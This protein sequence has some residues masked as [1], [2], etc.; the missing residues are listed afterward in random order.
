MWLQAFCH[1]LVLAGRHKFPCA[2]PRICWFLSQTSS[3]GRV[4]SRCITS[5]KQHA[6][7][8]TSKLAPGICTS[9]E[10][11]WCRWLGS[12]SGR[13]RLSPNALCFTWRARGILMIIALYCSIPLQ[14]GT[15]QKTPA[16][17][18]KTLM[19]STVHIAFL[20]Q[21]VTNQNQRK[22]SPSPKKKRAFSSLNS[23]RIFHWTLK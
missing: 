21:Q 22:C 1:N 18:N 4:R 5:V 14:H 17:R 19:S 3:V 11:N 15:S 10:A 8:Q 20:P 12:A 7:A 16:A 23:R 9:N 2:K 6:R 13:A